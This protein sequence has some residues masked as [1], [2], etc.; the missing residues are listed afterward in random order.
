MALEMGASHVI[1]GK[2]TDI[3][4]QIAKITG[5]KM[6]KQVVEAT[7]VDSCIKLAFNC[8][9]PR[10]IQAQ[11]GVFGSGRPLAIDCSTFQVQQKTVIGVR[12]SYLDFLSPKPSML[13]SD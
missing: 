5:G 2:D 9:S 10:G 12:K 7:G 11:V 4:E 13:S 1:N 8:L 6:L 3:I